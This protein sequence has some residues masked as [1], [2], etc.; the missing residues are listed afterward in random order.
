MYTH[1]VFRHQGSSVTELL[2]RNSKAAN[3]ETKSVPTVKTPNFKTPRV[4]K[5]ST[6]NTEIVHIFP[7]IRAI[8]SLE[9]RNS[10]Q[11][12][13]QLLRGFQLNS[14]HSQQSFPWFAVSETGL[15]LG[16]SAILVAHLQVVT[17]LGSSKRILPT[18]CSHP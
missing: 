12:L 10:Q 8:Y 1:T 7:V 6:E 15:T 9:H 11:Q 16:S 4:A 18:P 2:P 17:L 13:S 3:S 14:D 5:R